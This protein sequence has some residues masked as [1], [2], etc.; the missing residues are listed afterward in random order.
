MAFARVKI[1]PDIAGVSLVNKKTGDCVDV[2]PSAQQPGAQLNGAKLV[3][4]K[5]DGTQSQQWNVTV[6]TGNQTR[7]VNKLPSS[8]QF[9]LTDAGGKA[10]LEPTT[11]NN[12]L[13]PAERLK[14]VQIFSSRLV[15]VE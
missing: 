7:F 2:A 11:V 15:T 6:S 3:M 8:Q 9:A 14:H 1:A 13:P 5:C 12:N 10:I 4:A